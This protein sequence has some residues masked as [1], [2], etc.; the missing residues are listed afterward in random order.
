MAVADIRPVLE[1]G[2]NA[3]EARLRA[4]CMVTRATGNF[5]EDDQGYEVPEIVTIHEDLPCY[6]S[7]GGVPFETTYDSVGV[8]VT[9]GRLALV[10]GVGRD[11]VVDDVVTITEDIDSP[12][13]AG[14]SFRVASQVPRSQ[15]VKQT[16]LLED[17]QKG[18]K[19]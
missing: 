9:Q 13:L 4:T 15:G 6:L 17:N 8:A 19:T 2:R 18:V 5:V 14:S 16:V 12:W 11:I 10:T 3:Y 7:Y 1:M